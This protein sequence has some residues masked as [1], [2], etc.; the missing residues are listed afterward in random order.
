MK[1]LLSLLLFV[2]F[3][4][5][6]LCA[7]EKKNQFGFDLT[8]GIPMGKFSS[9]NYGNASTGFG[10]T[11]HFD[12][13]T[14]PKFSIGGEIGYL[15]FGDKS[16]IW[17][18]LQQSYSIFPIMG[19]ANI[20]FS[21]NENFRPHLTAGLG[22]AIENY[23]VTYDDGD[24]DYEGDGTITPFAI[25]LG[26]GFDKKL[27]GNTYVTFNLNYMSIFSDGQKIDIDGDEAE[28]TSNSDFLGFVVGLKF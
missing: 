2:L 1:R 16:K 12:H 15:N 14:S 27:S 17:D 13:F 11:G 18:D 20:Y 8:L 6:S 26:V 10:F 21:D 7:Q 28:V 23:S 5:N 19:R 22:I 3:V 4:V 9:S 24:Y 25:K